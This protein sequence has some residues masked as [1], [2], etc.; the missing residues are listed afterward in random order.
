MCARSM[1]RIYQ[2]IAG[3]RGGTSVA[4]KADDFG[5]LLIALHVL[6]GARR[7]GMILD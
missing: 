4:I 7:T 6:D 2:L 1:I 3:S 5:C